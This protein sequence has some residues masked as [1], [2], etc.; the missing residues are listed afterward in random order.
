VSS[1]AFFIGGKY[2]NK[3]RKLLNKTVS[4]LIATSIIIP[5]GSNVYAINDQGVVDNKS[6]ESPGVQKENSLVH[7]AIYRVKDDLG[8]KLN[9]YDSTNNIDLMN[10][11][12][13]IDGSDIVATAIPEKHY[14]ISKWIINGKSE[15]KELKEITFNE[16]KEDLD[17]EV[18]FERIKNKIN[19]ETNSAKPLESLIVN[20]GV[21]IDIT[22][23]PNMEGYIFEG[24]FLNKDFIGNKVETI[25][26]DEKDIT[27]Y[28]KWTRVF[29][30]DFDN[31]N[32]NG[33]IKVEVEGKE[34]NPG[35]LLE[36]G[37]EVLFTAE[38]NDGYIVKNW[39]VNST[40]LD[41]ETNNTLKL[42]NI[43]EDLRVSIEFKKKPSSGGGG[44]TIPEPKPEEIQYENLTGE[45][46]FDTS[47]KI[48]ENWKSSDSVVLV[49]AYSIVDAMTATP[50]AYFKDAPI[51]LTEKDKLNDISKSE[52]KR[53]KAKKIYII[54]GGNSISSELE[55]EL[56]N[57][58][59]DIERI[60]GEDRF[61]TS[62]N[63]G[64]KLGNVN[65]IMVVNGESGLAD[66]VS[67]GSVS[68][69]KKAP[70]FLANNKGDIP[71]LDEF[72]KAQNISK[73]Y[74]I[75]GENSIP[76]EIEKYLI[77]PERISGKDRNETNSK[78]IE[79]FFKEKILNNGYVVKN[80]IKSDSE[81]IDALS[82]GVLAAKNKSPII[83]VEDKLS[84]SQKEIF[85]KKDF[86]SL[87]KV[88]GNGNESAFNELKNLFSK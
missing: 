35:H 13:F 41:K 54:G 64:E 66:S 74:V 59:I 85:A 62:L 53:L 23:K 71:G 78:I 79:G 10:N 42:T 46:R 31:I 7:K 75:G 68:S 55:N 38:C 51:L 67:I 21:V 32:A 77:N 52:I 43:D 2:M 8:G 11:D 24:W 25:A 20:S 70:I 83:M 57:L 80:G 15:D 56:K 33:I 12:T 39:I 87:T 6:V 69:I 36:K 27:L 45:N 49:N 29:E 82:A 65:E 3:K 86:K 4:F 61:E 58:N 73:S 17:I 34:I 84:K 50:F 1:L 72:L 60:S 5:Y 48:S 63:I 37:Q 76:K 28:A 18:S 47:K 9:L 30:I 40:A 88:G 26:T 44:G 14:K 19:F 22:Q 81:L 16:R